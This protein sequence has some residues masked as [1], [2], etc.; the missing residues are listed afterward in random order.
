MREDIKYE[1]D[2]IIY[3]NTIYSYPEYN[4]KDIVPVAVNIQDKNSIKRC[5]PDSIWKKQ[6]YIMNWILFFGL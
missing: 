1:I 6:S 5:I 4:D 3:Q 2:G